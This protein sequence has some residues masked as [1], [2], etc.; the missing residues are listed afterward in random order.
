MS[1]ICIPNVSGSSCTKPVTLLQQGDKAPCKGFL[2]IPK[3]EQLAWENKLTVEQQLPKINRQK[4]LL[5]DDNKQLEQRIKK[6][7]DY[8]LK[9]EDRDRKS[10][11]WDS[12]ENALWF[13]SGS[14]ITGLVAK[15]VL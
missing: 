6:W 12:L 15:E 13:I 8:A 14:L 5:L 1:F 9:L 11:I 2:F 10:R 7:K 3:E 4:E